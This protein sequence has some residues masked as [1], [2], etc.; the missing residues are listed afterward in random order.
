[1]V[2]IF[3][4]EQLFE[5]HVVSCDGHL[6]IALIAVGGA[7]EQK[8]CLEMVVTIS[9]SVQKLVQISVYSPVHESRPESRVHVFGNKNA[10]GVVWFTRRSTIA[11]SPGPG[12]TS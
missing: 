8:V 1:M 4:L 3:T 2:A 5:C 12:P 10:V 9:D 7:L 6:T 11:S